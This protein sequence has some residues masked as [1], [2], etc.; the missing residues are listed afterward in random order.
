M[1]TAPELSERRRD[2]GKIEV[3]RQPIPE[4]QRQTDGDRRVAEKVRV[5]LIAVKKNTD[6]AVLGRQSLIQRV[7]HIGGYLIEVVGH[8]QL[9]EIS[10]DQPFR[11]L[12]SGDI[13][14]EFCLICGRN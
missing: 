13:D 12:Y 8:E 11:G 9:E 7:V 5:N 3:L 6:S 2:I 14:Q 1:P 4:Q 10:T